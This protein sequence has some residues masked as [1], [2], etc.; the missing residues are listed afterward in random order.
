[1]DM[2]KRDILGHGHDHFY[3]LV[4]PA[5]DSPERE[6]GRKIVSLPNHTSFSIPS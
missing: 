2:M 3:E 1:M 4:N 6:M 5:L